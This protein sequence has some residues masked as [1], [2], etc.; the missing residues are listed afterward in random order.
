[1]VVG[2]SQGQ[3]YSHDHL[4]ATQERVAEELARPQGNGGLG[5]GHLRGL[6]MLP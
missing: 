5:V 2:G 3:V 1:M 4:L 6:V